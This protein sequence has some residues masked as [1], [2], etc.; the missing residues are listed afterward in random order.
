MAD[1]DKNINQIENKL[2]VFTDILNRM[3]VSKSGST[4]NAYLILTELISYI[5]STREEV[6]ERPEIQP[7]IVTG[8]PNILTIDLNNRKQGLFEPRLSVGTLSINID[9][10][11]IISNKTNG[12]LISSVLS[13]TGTRIIKFESDVLVSNASTLG[14]WDGGAKTLTIT[15]GTDDLIEF[16]YIRYKTSSKWLLKVGEVAI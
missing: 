13:L 2:S 12:D 8:S 10:D 7:V 6:I 16:Q 15:A 11:F 9:F 4:K 14:T 1:L 3:Y 5:Q